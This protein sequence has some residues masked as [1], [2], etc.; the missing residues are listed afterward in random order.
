MH[1]LI[2]DQLWALVYDECSRIEH[3]RFKDDR[4]A[5]AALE[6]NNRMRKCLH[7]LFERERELKREKKELV[8][9]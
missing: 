4:D 5:E 9:S 8:E 3:S 2:D 1:D 7:L 6:A